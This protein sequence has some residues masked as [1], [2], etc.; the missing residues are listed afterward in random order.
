MKV[1]DLR[2]NGYKVRVI[3]KRNVIRPKIKGTK[4]VNSQ[5]LMTKREIMQLELMNIDYIVSPFGGE[6]TVEVT[7]P[8]G[9]NYT[10]ITHTKNEQFNRKLALNVAM[11]R[12]AKILK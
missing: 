8:D 6:T 12:I 2:D 11:G 7:T 5:Q 4:F 1:Q 9:N 3:H 10:A